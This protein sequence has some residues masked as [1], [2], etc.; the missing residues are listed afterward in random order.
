MADLVLHDSLVDE[1]LNYKLSINFDKSKTQKLL[2]Y[3]LPFPVK[4]NHQ[5]IDPSMPKQLEESDP[6]IEISDELNDF[7]LVQSSRLKLMLIDKAITPLPLFTTV[8]ISG[9]LP[10]KLQPKYGATYPPNATDKNKAQEHIKALLS[11]ASW[12]IITDGYIANSD[13]ITNKALISAL[14]PNDN[15]TITIVGA[16]ISINQPSLDVTKKLEIE[17][18]CSNWT[19]NCSAMNST[20]THDRYIETNK[21]KILLSSGLY[22][23]STSSQKDFTYVIEL[24]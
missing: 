12:V 10:E 17:S 15:I 23:L 9:I 13:W 6:L 19:V 21:V 1:Y 5:L 11:D 7:D 3:I 24:K 2:K 14:L 18:L 20:I 8:N 22:H 4:I 16:N